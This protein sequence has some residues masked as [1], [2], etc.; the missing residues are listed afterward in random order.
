M[1]PREELS[2][3]FRALIGTGPVFTPKDLRHAIENDPGLSNERKINL[4]TIL[5]SPNIA[6]QL[7]AGA[8]GAAVGVALAKYKKLSNTAQTLMGLAGFGLGNIIMNSLTQP[9]KFTSW[10][11]NTATAK[12]LL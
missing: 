11:P 8:S 4:F 7:L 2:P 1:I 9:G 12:V 6:E 10:D 5:N 3:A